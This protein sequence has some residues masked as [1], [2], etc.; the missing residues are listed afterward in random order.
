LG[1]VLAGM[2]PTSPPNPEKKLTPVAWTKSHTGESGKT[3]RVFTT[4]MGHPV[5][6][7][8]EGFRRMLVNACYWA[9][10]MEKRISAKSSVEFTGPYSPNPIGMGKHRRGVKLSDLRA[11]K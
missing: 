4:T 5:D 10:G 1:Q 11:T 6:F 8:S 2:Q 9:L 7:K 3:A